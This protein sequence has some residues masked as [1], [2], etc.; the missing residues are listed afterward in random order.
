[1]SWCVKWAP[2]WV[3]SS[4]VDHQAQSLG[5]VKIIKHRTSKSL[6]PSIMLEPADAVQWAGPLRRPSSSGRWVHRVIWVYMALCAMLFDAK[7]ST[8]QVYSTKKLL[9]KLRVYIDLSGS[10]VVYIDESISASS[11]SYKSNSKSA[12][13]NLSICIAWT[14]ENQ[15]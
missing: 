1:M 8:F 5:G 10:I 15:S 3:R 12:A 9:E 7:G 11:R 14:Y 4:S 2:Y 6:S 13:D